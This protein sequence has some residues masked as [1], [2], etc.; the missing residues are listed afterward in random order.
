LIEQ[1]M[2]KKMGFGFLWER[3]EMG[4]GGGAWWWRMASSGV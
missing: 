1:K 4:A 3:W 2:P